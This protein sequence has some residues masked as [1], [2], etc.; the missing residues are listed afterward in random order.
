MRLHVLG[1]ATICIKL[2]APTI[3][4]MNR[5]TPG[6]PGPLDESGEARWGRSQIICTDCSRPAFHRSVGNQE[7]DDISMYLHSSFHSPEPPMR[8]VCADLAKSECNSQM[9]ACSRAYTECGLFNWVSL[10]TIDWLSRYAATGE[11][12]GCESVVPVGDKGCSSD[13]SPRN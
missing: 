11:P 1:R 3:L 6:T 9:V 10:F 7:I 8:R 12:A 5:T 2:R 4:A 13:A